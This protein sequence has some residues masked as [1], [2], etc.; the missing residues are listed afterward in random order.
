M[1]AIDPASN[2]HIRI[3]WEDLAVGDSR[4]LGSLT[5]TE[6]EIVAFARQYDPQPFHLDPEAARHSV[7]GALCA[8][9]WHTCALAMRL[10][11][12]NFLHESSS[13]GSPGLESLKWLKPVFPGDELRLRHTIVDKRPMGK[14][15]DV[16][17]VRTVWALFNQH[18]EQVLHMEGWG[19]FRRREPGAPPQ[20]P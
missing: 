15:P 17:L 7:F 6:E 2:P 19:M 18:G 4:D 3:W 10:M 14:R 11:V 5:V 9:G 1:T 20:S 16:G 8:S 13:L 12:T